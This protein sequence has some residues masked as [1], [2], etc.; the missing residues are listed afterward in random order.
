[1][2]SLIALRNQSKVDTWRAKK[3]SSVQNGYRKSETHARVFPKHL[4]MGTA[5]LQEDK[6]TVECKQ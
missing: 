4:R 3:A 1:M 2:F 5:R 6:E